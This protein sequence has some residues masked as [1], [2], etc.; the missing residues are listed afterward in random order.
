VFLSLLFWAFLATYL[1]HLL[2]RHLLSGSDF[3]IG[4]ILGVATVGSFLTVGTTLLFPW[5]TRRRQAT[6]K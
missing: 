6:A 3:T 4:T 2:G 1:M 5:L